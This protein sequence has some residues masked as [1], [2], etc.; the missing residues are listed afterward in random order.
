V[1]TSGID[2]AARA[3]RASAALN[4]LRAFYSVASA[5]AIKRVKGRHVM[6][7]IYDGAEWTDMD[8]EDLK[9]AIAH[10]RSRGSREYLVRLS[11]RTGVR[12]ETGKE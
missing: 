7:D 11:G 12:R 4:S 1:R 2:G 8:I 10:G 5:F 3:L 6:T 9:A